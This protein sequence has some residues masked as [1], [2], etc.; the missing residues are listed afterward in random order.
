MGGTPNV[1]TSH[2]IFDAFEVK[3]YAHYVTTYVPDTKR[4]MV[5]ECDATI[6]NAPRKTCKSEDEWDQL[7][8]PLM[9]PN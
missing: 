6:P 7:V 3:E 1:T 4:T 2:I 5:M 8:E 9:G